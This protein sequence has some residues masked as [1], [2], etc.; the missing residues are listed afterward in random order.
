VPGTV[1]HALKTV[2]GLAAGRSE[3]V[4]PPP[5][6][7]VPEAHIDAIL[8]VL[9]TPVRAM[10]EIMRLTGARVGE[11]VQMRRADIDVSGRVWVYTPRSHKSQHHGKPRV[12]YL[13]PRAQ[14]VLKPWLRADLE[15]P[16]FSARDTME[17]MWDERRRSRKRK[18][19]PSELKRLERPRK[20]RREFYSRDSVRTAVRLACLKTG[21]PVWHPHQLRHNAGTY[22]RREYGVDMARIILGHSD[23]KTTEIYAEADHAAAIKIME[24]VG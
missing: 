10:V 1:H 3:A 9:S 11:V 16:M 6:G 22:I 24:R 21:T 23:L 7:P 19:K 5:V 12:I 18:L 17:R 20:T 8:P 13:G 14:R 4:E 2:R 15:A